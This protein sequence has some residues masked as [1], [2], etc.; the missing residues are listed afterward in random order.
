MS[1]LFLEKKHWHHLCMGTSFCVVFEHTVTE[2]LSLEGTSW[3]H[4]VWLL[5]LDV[6]Q[7]SRTMSRYT[8]TVGE[9]ADSFG[10]LCQCLII[11]F[12]IFRQI[13]FDKI[14]FLPSFIPLLNIWMIYF[15]RGIKEEKS[16]RIFEVTVFKQILNIYSL[17]YTS[18]STALPSSSAL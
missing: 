7:L 6:C 12:L 9:S 16:L 2:W 13:L 1:S 4:L 11:H 8:S 14:L 15:G 18:I 17:L 10:K 5:L 3:D